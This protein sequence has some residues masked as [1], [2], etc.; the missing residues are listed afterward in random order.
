MQ[1]VRVIESYGKHAFFRQTD[2]CFCIIESEEEALPI[3]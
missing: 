3:Y 2:A 1:L